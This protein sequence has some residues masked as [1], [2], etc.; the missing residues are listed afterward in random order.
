MPKWLTILARIGPQILLFTPLAQIAPI[1]VGAI[2]AAE[3]LPGAT[4]PQK[5]TLVQQIAIAGAQAV[6]AAAGRMI[7]DPVLAEQASGAAIDT[8]VT[9]TNLINKATPENALTPQ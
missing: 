3:G 4:G 7:I 6:N 9:V 2:Q 5:K 8:V 1:I